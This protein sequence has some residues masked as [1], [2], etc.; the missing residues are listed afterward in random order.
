MS[1]NVTVKGDYMYPAKSVERSRE[2][3][4]WKSQILGA[5][6]YKHRTCSVKTYSLQ[7]SGS[8]LRNSWS[9]AYLLT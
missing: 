2:Q 4:D 9:H 5:L 3:G 7:I 1:K 6:L 8:L